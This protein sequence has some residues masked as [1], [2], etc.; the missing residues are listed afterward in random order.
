MNPTS[1]T[2]CSACYLG[3]EPSKRA[4]RTIFA[5]CHRCKSPAARSFTGDPGT[6]WTNRTDRPAYQ[7]QPEVHEGAG[8]CFQYATHVGFLWP[9]PFVPGCSCKQK[10]IWP[11]ETSL[12]FVDVGLAIRVLTEGDKWQ[13][14]GKN[15]WLLIASGLVEWKDVVRQHV[16][17]EL[18]WVIHFK[19]LTV[20]QLVEAGVPEADAQEAW[21]KAYTPERIEADQKR[22]QAIQDLR[23][24]GLSDQ[25]IRIEIAKRLGLRV[26]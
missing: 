25:Q 1:R 9:T 6:V 10:P 3:H 21:N 11:G 4:P 7:L 5:V 8:M 20:A 17:R 23:D 14:V 19:R 24:M 12:P 18:E 16:V 26:K 15:N 22:R 13:L 2:V